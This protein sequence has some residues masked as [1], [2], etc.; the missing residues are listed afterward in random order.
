MFPNR[1]PISVLESGWLATFRTDF[2]KALSSQ[3]ALRQY[4]AQQMSTTPY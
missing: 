1:D 4:F 2:R 3:R